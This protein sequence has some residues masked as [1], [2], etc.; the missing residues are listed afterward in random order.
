MRLLSCNVVSSF[1]HCLRGKGLLSFQML[2]YTFVREANLEC[3]F[4]IVVNVAICQIWSEFLSVCLARF[5]I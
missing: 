4:L 5:V 2:K 3:L 1:M